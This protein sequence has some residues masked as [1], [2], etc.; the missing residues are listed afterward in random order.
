MNDDVFEFGKGRVIT[1]GNDVAIIATGE[2]VYPALQAA[3]N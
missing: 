3:K 1:E 2:T